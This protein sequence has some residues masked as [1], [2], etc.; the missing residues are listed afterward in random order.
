MN[1]I[2]IRVKRPEGYEDVAPEL[3]A[4]DFTRTATTALP[5]WDWSIMLEAELASAKERG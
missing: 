5:P 1:D 3:V 2:I 4:E